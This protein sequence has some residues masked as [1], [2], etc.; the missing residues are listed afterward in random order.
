MHKSQW[1]KFR[2]LFIYALLLLSAASA[3]YAA[4][5]LVGKD[6]PDFTLR[7]HQEENIK[8]SEYYG[9]VVMLNFWAT[10]CGPCRQ[11]IPKLTELKNLHNEYDFELLGINIDED[12][13]KARQLA[14]KL[15]VNYPILFDEEKGVAKSYQ[16]DAMPMTVLIGRDGK[17]RY[18]HRGYKE[19]YL[20]KYQQ[21]IQ[22]LKAE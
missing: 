17:V 18:I 3:V 4:A 10:W 15:S 16:V 19:E 14:K 22:K 6:A 2:Q 11:E 20:A 12:Q 13:D 9:K 5:K 8:L 7:G 1:F 21:Q